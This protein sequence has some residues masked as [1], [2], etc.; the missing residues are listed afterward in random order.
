MPC[1]CTGSEPPAVSAYMPGGGSHARAS[2]SENAASARASAERPLWRDLA[3]AAAVP[4]ALFT[5]PAWPD[6]TPIEAAG[7]AVV[8][9]A[10]EVWQPVR[11]PDG[12]TGWVKK[13]YL[14]DAHGNALP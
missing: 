10:G 13:R 1:A 2:A 7:A 8:G 11:A 12:S 9:S 4:G 3:E 5:T 6:N 14:L